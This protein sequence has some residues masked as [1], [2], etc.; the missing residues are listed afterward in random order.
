[1]ENINFHKV[2]NLLDSY[3]N[4]L[5][6]KENQ[7]T[8]PNNNE[9]IVF[10]PENSIIKILEAI[11]TKGYKNFDLLELIQPDEVTAKIKEIIDKT[12]ANP[13]SQLKL[14]LAF[15]IVPSE[16]NKNYI[17]LV[18]YELEFTNEKLRV[19][20]KTLNK[21]ELNR[22]NQKTDKHFDFNKIKDDNSKDDI[23]IH[24][25]I[26]E[27]IMELSHLC[28][29]VM[30]IPEP[31]MLMASCYS[32]VRFL[33]GMK[34]LLPELK[35]ILHLNSGLLSKL[36]SAEEKFANTHIKDKNLKEFILSPDETLAVIYPYDDT[37]YTGNVRD[38]ITRIKNSLNDKAVEKIAKL[39]S[40]NPVQSVEDLSGYRYAFLSHELTESQKTAYQ[41][42]IS[43][44]F[45]L[46]EGPPGTGKTQLIVTF[47]ADMILKN[48]TVVVTSTNN[49]AVDNVLNKLEEFDN[50]IKDK[51]KTGKILKG[52][53][54][55]GQKEKMNQF[56]EEIFNFLKEAEQY[57]SEEIDKNLKE[58]E[59]ET[60]ILEDFI[61]AY[62]KYKKFQ[63]ERSIC[64]HL[65]HF[66]TEEKMY[67]FDETSFETLTI[68]FNKLNSW[69][70]NV[71]PFS[72]LNAKK[73]LNKLQKYCEEKGI[74]LK[75]LADIKYLTCR[76][77]Y[78]R[79]KETI[80][81]LKNVADYN[82]L[83]QNVWKEFEDA[84]SKII[85][86][87]GEEITEE[88]LFDEVRRL[89]YIRKRE[90]N[91]WRLA[92]DKNWQSNI[93]R[94]E[95][96]ITKLQLWGLEKEIFKF[97]PVIITTALS[98]T[99]LC[100]PELDIIDYVIVD[101]ASQTLFCY[102]FPLYFRAKHFIAIGDDNQLDPVLSENYQI[103]TSEDIP[104]HLIY[105]KST[106]D[107]VKGVLK[108]AGQKPVRL[109]EH[110]RCVPSIIEFC[111]KLV[112]YGLSI[113][114]KEKKYQFS[115]PLAQPVSRLFEK[116]LVFVH[117]D[118][119]SSGKNSKCNHK[120]IHFIKNLLTCLKSCIE[121]PHDIGVISPY[122]LHIDELKKELAEIQ[123]L[124]LG[125]VH[126]FQGEER[127]IIILSCVCGTK[128]EFSKSQ[129]LKDKRLINVAVSR[130]RTHLIVVG[131]K[132]AIEQCQ[133]LPIKQL[134]EHILKKGSVVESSSIFS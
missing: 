109:R 32:V 60:K 81:E 85:S 123:G 98:S 52:Y 107:G 70:S 3:L 58:L 99:K 50:S 130:A 129:L 67:A 53:A 21:N 134:Y 125:T 51:L 45:S 82:A 73:C 75:A 128:E 133:N 63:T 22:L 34:N 90:E 79:E 29:L 12:I 43:S 111:D 13:E 80:D 121:N 68:L 103:E 131:N 89:Y 27:V 1:M 105:T 101:E 124:T 7:F 62:N 47:C 84:K 115:V 14:G 87:F 122:R 61:T 24:K 66:I 126:T 44:E 8:I 2:Q 4:F 42:M 71:P 25:H 38:D 88:K 132:K 41:N 28:H 23:R 83:R 78:T 9:N 104:D 31:V 39:W 17:A 76:E 18:R 69:H 77:I 35:K 30:P 33:Q 112:G 59:Q 96:K 6:Y 113:Q 11:V 20:K 114:T 15:P 40:Y 117:I 55:L 95:D 5:E 110:F 91:Y 106:F 26:I 72:W 56:V 36:D 49:K 74:I 100:K 116:N 10:I 94:N 65:Q 92:K 46:I 57:T 127:D 54:R 120:E 93:S 48:K 16:D 108:N 119:K 102:T 37:E 64:N 97:S 118:G 19:T 86:L